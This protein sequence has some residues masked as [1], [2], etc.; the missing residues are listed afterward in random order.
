MPRDVY[1]VTSASIEKTGKGYELFVL[2]LDGKIRATQLIPTRRTDQAFD[3]VYQLY[4][5]NGS[6]ITDLVGKYLSLRL[7]ETR[8]GFQF[9][10]VGSCDAIADFKLLL[11]R[12]CGKAFHTDLNIIKILSR[13]GYQANPDDSITLR[14]D[15]SNLNVIRKN[16]T[17]ICYSNIVDYTVL[18]LENMRA[19]YDRFY[20]DK[21]V[22]TLNP[23]RI[24]EYALHPSR[25]VESYQRYHEDNGKLLSR[26]DIS[27]LSLGDRLTQEQLEY[28]AYIHEY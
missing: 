24:S 2:Q 8:Y 21:K 9:S 7:E 11:D 23:D 13:N 17:V 18:T 15:Y 22:E 10:S 28:L 25:I 3:K 12:S 1:K 20:K 16:D 6:Q 4:I 26:G 27:V 14:G 5:S 19:I